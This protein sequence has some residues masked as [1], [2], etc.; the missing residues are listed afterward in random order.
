MSQRLRN[1]DGTFRPLEDSDYEVHIWFERDRAHV[2]LSKPS[3]KTVFDL[4]DEAVQ[5]AIE[6]GFL[7]TPVNRSSVLEYARDQGLI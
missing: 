5:E 6:D 3:G 4:W 1:L 7:E 2:G